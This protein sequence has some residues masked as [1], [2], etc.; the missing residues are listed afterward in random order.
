M[1]RPFSLSLISVN[2]QFQELTVRFQESTSE[3]RMQCSTVTEPMWF[4]FSFRI[5]AFVRCRGGSRISEKGVHMLKGVGIRFA[6]FIS[7]FLSRLTKTEFFHFHRITNVGQRGF[8]RALC[9]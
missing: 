3:I 1:K 4:G 7:F 9:N 8:K 6:D 2:N 5:L